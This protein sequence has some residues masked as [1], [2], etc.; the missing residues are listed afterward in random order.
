MATG[1]IVFGPA[2][3]ETSWQEAR[4]KV[5]ERL[6]R[7]STSALPNDEVDEAL[8]NALR[9]IEA[10]RRWLWLENVSASL[11]MPA[12]GDNVGLPSS[13]GAITSLAFIG[14]STD[15][16]IYD[17]LQETN[18]AFVRQQARG[19]SPGDPTFY[20]RSD[21][22]LYFD[23]PVA[24]G[25][26]FEIVFTSQCPQYI[27]LAIDTPPIT[28]TLQT[29]AVVAR[30]CWYLALFY[31]KDEE[32]AAR[33]A[34]AYDAM[35]GRMMVEEDTRRADGQ[36]GGRIVPDDEHYRAAHGVRYG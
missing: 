23:C 18:L 2:A 19:D 33:Q 27:E 35:L 5:R 25:D 4:D 28:L 29:T 14:G 24:E 16:T 12:Q 9:D 21:N 26:K 10:E 7:R 11:E 8:H 3:A 34:T 17:T 31:L 15:T 36:M 1:T 13:V 30:A 6:W 32:E 20:A 22:Q